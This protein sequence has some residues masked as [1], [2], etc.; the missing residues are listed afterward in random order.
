M[1]RK[2]FIKP[3]RSRAIPIEWMLVLRLSAAALPHVGI[4]RLAEHGS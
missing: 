1:I 3:L 2:A 4:T